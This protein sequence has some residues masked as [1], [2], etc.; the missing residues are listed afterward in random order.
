MNHCNCFSTPTLRCELE[1]ATIRQ[2]DRLKPFS[3]IVV[4]FTFEHRLV[5]YKSTSDRNNSAIECFSPSLARYELTLVIERTI[6]RLTQLY[7]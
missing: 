1:L 3:P 6:R 7:T 5:L 2:A 4:A